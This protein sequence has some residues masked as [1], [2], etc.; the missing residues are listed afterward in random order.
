MASAH[1][2]QVSFVLATHNRCEVV[3]DTLAQ[4]ARCELDRRDYE[5]IAVDNASCDGTPQRIAS[6]VDRLVRL[7]HNAGSC[8][9]AFGVEFLRGRYVVFL[10]DDSYPRPGSVT[11]MIARFEAD[12]RLGAAGFTVHLPDGRKEG[13]ALPGV[14]VGCGVGLRTDALKAVGGLDHTFFMQAE[15]YDLSFRLVAEGWRVQVFDDLHVEHMKTPHARKTDRTTYHDVRNNLR[16]VARYL[17]APF[18]TIY[19]ADW[20]QRY[21]WLATRDGHQRSFSRGARAGRWRGR[22]ERW[23]YRSRRLGSNALE[24]F[25]GW[26]RIRLCMADLAASGIRRIVLA[27]LGKNCFPYYRGARLAGITVTA[28]GDDRFTA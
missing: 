13:G 3:G 5:V 6:R 25:F 9:K 15:E 12:R 4:I 19:R 27:D 26:E 17:P 28:V 7:N 21:R 18:H 1:L 10:D 8:A 16:I 14:F 11:R 20:F 22:L 23:T 24:Y 2:P